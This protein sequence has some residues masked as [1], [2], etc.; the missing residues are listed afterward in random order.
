MPS[1]SLFLYTPLSQTQSFIVTVLLG[2]RL[3]C[4]CSFDHVSSM[5]QTSTKFKFMAGFNEPEATIL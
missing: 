1:H 4:I 2:T 5:V 3:C